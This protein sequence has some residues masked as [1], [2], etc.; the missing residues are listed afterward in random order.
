M[1]LRERVEW[2]LIIVSALVGWWL[3]GR[4]PRR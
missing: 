3:A 4:Y 1:T 2:A